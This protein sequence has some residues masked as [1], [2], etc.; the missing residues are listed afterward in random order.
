M[1]FVHYDVVLITFNVFFTLRMKNIL[2]KNRHIEKNHQISTNRKTRRHD[3]RNRKIR[4]H[5]FHR[6]AKLRNSKNSTKK[7]SQN[8]QNFDVKIALFTRIQNQFFDMK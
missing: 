5:D 6:F 8:S 2:F 4:F 3:C 1:F 7:S